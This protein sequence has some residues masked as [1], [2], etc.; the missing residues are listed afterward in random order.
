MQCVGEEKPLYPNLSL[1]RLRKWA[2]DGFQRHRFSWIILHCYS[3]SLRS[4]LA[5]GLTN[6]SSPALCWAKTCEGLKLELVNSVTGAMVCS[7]A[8]VRI[9]PSHHPSQTG[10]EVRKRITN[11]R[12][13]QRTKTCRR[14]DLLNW[15]SL[16]KWCL[17]LIQRGNH[18]VSRE[19]TA[20]ASPAD[21]PHP[22]C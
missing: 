12:V 2:T 9:L 16:T 1:C 6:S 4:T 22:H 10:T 20:F 3:F 21:S 13:V 17:D 7:I 11:Y 15:N 8:L 18:W 19:P 5:A 14:E